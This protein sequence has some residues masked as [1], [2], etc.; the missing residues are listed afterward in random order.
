MVVRAV[1]LRDADA[2]RRRVLDSAEALFAQKGIDGVRLREI[3]DRAKVTVP[4]LCHHFGDKE[5]LY[6]AVIDRTMERFAALGWG[7]LRA[8]GSFRERLDAMV[9]GLID[10]LASDPIA[11]NLLHRELVDGGTRALPIAERW[12][13]PLKDAASAE[14]RLGQSRGE[15]RAELDP[16][17]L[18]LHIVGAAMYP[19]VA[20]P[21]VRVVWGADPLAGALLERRKRELSELL[22]RLVTP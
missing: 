11:T 18:V 12:F 13:V 9:S 15:V 10:L 8:A 20:A 3:A 7:V 14:I 6:T 4:L 21:I 2:T 22:G 5:A 16:E 17:L 19:S 1:R